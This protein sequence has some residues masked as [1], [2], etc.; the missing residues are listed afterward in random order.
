MSDLYGEQY[1]SEE[2]KDFLDL[3]FD[4]SNPWKDEDMPF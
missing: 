2:A 3:V 4:Y 1:L